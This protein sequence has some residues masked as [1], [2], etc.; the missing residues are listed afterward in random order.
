[1]HA[2]SLRGLG[3][4]VSAAAFVAAPVF[5]QNSP[6]ESDEA[7]KDQT[8]ENI[9]VT[10]SKRETSLLDSDLSVTVLNATAIEDA[11][12]RDFRRI[13]D[14]NPNVQFNESGQR[15]SIFITVRGVESNPFIINRAAVYIDGIPFR[16]LS[17]SVLSQIESI[18][19][20]RGPQ[21]T[22][23]GANTE[24]GLII[25]NTK[26]PSDELTG[27]IRLTGSH[28]SSGEAFEGS[29]NIGGP[30]IEGKLAG[31]L[32]F[33]IAR[34]DAYVKNEGT[35]TQ[36]TGHIDETFLQGRLHWT[37]TDRLTVNTTAYWLKMK[38]P[39]IFDTEYVPLDIDLY[40]DSY[41]DAFNSGQ[42]IGDYT[43]LN[44]A[45]KYSDEEEFVLGL[46]ATYELGEGKIDLAASY[47]DL[48]EN[49]SGLDFD[50]TAA[51]FVSGQEIE[52][53]KYRHLEVRYSSPEGQLFDYIVGASYYEDEEER[54]LASFIGA[55]TLDS[56]IAAP[57]QYKEG[58]DVSVFGSANLYVSSRLKFGLG[59]RYDHAKRRTIQ[60]EGEL[61][62]GFGSVVS[63]RDAD[64]SENFDALLPR[65]SAHYSV[66]DQFSVHASVSRGY[67]PGG[68][69]LAAVQDGIDDENI[70]S[71]DSEH[72][73]SREIGFKWQSED[74][75]VRMAG[76]IFYITADNWQEIQIA[77]DE[78]GRPVS[79]DYIG[80]DASIRSMGAEWELHWR[81]SEALVFDGH[82]GYVDSEYRNLQLAEDLNVEGQPVQFVPEYD[83][84]AAVRYEWPFGL[85]ARAEVGFTGEIPLRARGDIF[86]K[87]VTTLGFQLGYAGETY[88]IRLFGENLTNER[89]ASGLAI[90]NLAFGTDGNFY[91]PLDAP[92]VIG[93]EL[94][95]SF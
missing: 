32:S 41:A 70:I 57:A 55:G 58:K 83:A 50:L 29:G 2:K 78:T 51:P 25:V 74:A 68:F 93:I 17:N 67:I 44:D 12:L 72:L 45:P 18:E 80:S 89:R 60:R 49:A 31:S 22:L 40:N 62:L 73:W 65:L 64:L 95:A 86:Q 76:A 33:N 91:G 56:Y 14:L 9:V 75:L 30:I 26:A 42:R 92:R 46:S 53:E 61:D 34:E 84:G 6:S 36:E 47:R 11:R 69:N 85:F 54:T 52:A 21:G 77:T 1:M 43:V 71:Y 63:Y 39:G 90:E 66:S 28:Y 15:G 88:A 38:A 5:A 3:A 16:E 87:A 82:V 48:D 35:S 27:N 23:Y 4:A 81:L 24:S 37:P 79:S 13:D 8:I 19:V 10:G 94:E 59:L 7:G 20:L